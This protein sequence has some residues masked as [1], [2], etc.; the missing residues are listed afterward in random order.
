MAE[1]IF[2]NLLQYLGNNRITDAYASSAKGAIGQGQYLQDRLA[3]VGEKAKQSNER[4]HQIAQAFAGGKRPPP[5][6]MKGLLDEVIGMNPITGGV[7][8]P[9]GNKALQS[10]WK[11]LENEAPKV[12]KAA[13]DDPRTLFSYLVNPSSMPG[14]AGRGLSGAYRSIKSTL[15]PEIPSQAGEAYVNAVQ[16]LS[17]YLP[18]LMHETGHFNTEPLLAG[19]SAGH[20]LETA[21]QLGQLSPTRQRKALERYINDAERAINVGKSLP[22]NLRPEAKGF[23]PTGTSEA[24]KAYSEARSYLQE[25]LLQPTT[26]GGD[27]MLGLIADA[28]GLGL[29]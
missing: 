9:T 29:R 4:S 8:A 2:D 11:Q 22:P 1:G 25:S 17:E 6:L 13:Q 7:I 24:R 28:L 18:A 5:E 3:D 26:A 23:D 15:H 20:A 10:L 21:T 14:A 19:K 27:P 16:R 12:Y